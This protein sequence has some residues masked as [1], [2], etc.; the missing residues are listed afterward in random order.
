MKSLPSDCGGE[1]KL[2]V[3][4]SSPR[5]H[6]PVQNSVLVSRQS[7]SAFAVSTPSRSALQK[8]R[9]KIPTPPPP[10][11]QKQNKNRNGRVSC[12]THVPHE[13]NLLGCTLWPRPACGS[14]HGL[15]C[16]KLSCL[17]LIIEHFWVC[18]VLDE[19]WDTWLAHDPKCSQG[20]INEWGGDT[21]FVS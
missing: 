3:L 21:Y 10:P 12:S 2:L 7:S 8:G 1:K 16:R 19:L 9:K 18:L 4:V 15:C 13:R 5:S 14:M 6:V 17:G 11:K 20:L